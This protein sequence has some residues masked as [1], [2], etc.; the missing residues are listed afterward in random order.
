M[1]D[2]WEML[3][4]VKQS[5]PSSAVSERSGRQVS[6]NHSPSGHRHFRKHIPSD[7]ESQLKV[8]IFA[9]FDLLSCVI[10]HTL[11]GASAFTYDE[12]C[13]ALDSQD[14]D[15]ELFELQPASRASGLQQ[16]TLT[17][18]NIDLWRLVGLSDL[19]T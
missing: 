4:R 11:A 8:F 16:S 9:I 1:G 17:G 10:T 3:K 7:S 14:P 13:A 5:N 6:T 12:P 15:A 19:V 18:I 2:E